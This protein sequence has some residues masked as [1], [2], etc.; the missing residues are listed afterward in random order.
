MG[1][2]ECAPQ[3]FTTNQPLK[4]FNENIASLFFLTSDIE[5]FVLSCHW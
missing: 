2:M 4:V 1:K 3:H 5:S